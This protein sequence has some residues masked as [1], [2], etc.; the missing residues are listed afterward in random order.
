[1][2]YSQNKILTFFA[3]L[4]HQMVSKHSETNFIKFLSFRAFYWCIKLCSK[5]EIKFWPFS[6]SSAT[7]WRFSKISTSKS[8]CFLNFKFSGIFHFSGTF[9]NLHPTQKNFVAIGRVKNS[10]CTGQVFI[11]FQY[12]N[13]LEWFFEKIKKSPLKILRRWYFFD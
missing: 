4:R 9:P 7:R 3:T 10:T 8:S 13:D 1:M 11:D 5:A 2:L 12:Y 6:P